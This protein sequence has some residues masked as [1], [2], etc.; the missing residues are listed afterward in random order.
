MRHV[1]TVSN[2]IPKKKLNH[3]ITQHSTPLLHL[4]LILRLHLSHLGRL[5][6]KIWDKRERKCRERNVHL[7]VIQKG[8]KQSATSPDMHGHD[9]EEAPDVTSHS[10]TVSNR[11]Q[12]SSKPETQPEEKIESKGTVSHS[13]Q[14]Q[15]CGR[16][17][18]L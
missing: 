11:S 7:K 2:H 13:I 12:A 8:L 15:R 4:R 9:P 16:L 10:G 3:T 5:S 14:R 18:L 1:A 6:P 17:F